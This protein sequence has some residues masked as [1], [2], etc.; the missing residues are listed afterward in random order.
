[1]IVSHTNKENNVLFNNTHNSQQ[2]ERQVHNNKKS[3]KPGS[4][5]SGNMNLFQDDITM[6]KVMA[7][8]KALKTVIDTYVNDKKIDDNVE[9]RRQHILELEEECKVYNEELKSI[10]DKKQQLKEEYGIGDD[11]REN[12]V[13]SELLEEYQS[14][15]SE[16]DKRAAEYQKRVEDT[17]YLINEEAKVISGIEKE[18]L[19][20][21]PMVKADKKATDI[22]EEAGKEIIGM[23]LDDTKEKIDKD[24]KEQKENMEEEAKKEEEEKLRL[25]AL[26]AEKEEKE[27]KNRKDNPSIDNVMNTQ[28][29][30]QI[31]DASVSQDKLQTDIKTMLNTQVVLDEDLKGMEVDEIL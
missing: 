21:D 20:S 15:A 1:M 24:M 12:P 7:H 27:G 4:I 19:K 23:V 9:S 26:K 18:R 5:Y 31:N 29:L 8:K 13:S 17:K 3:T 30:N 11:Y 25:E 28:L 22:L 14:L 16:Y 2:T 10:E 6:K